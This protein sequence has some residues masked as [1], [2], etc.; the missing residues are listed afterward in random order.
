MSSRVFW[1]Q[2]KWVMAAQ[3]QMDLAEQN[4]IMAKLSKKGIH[5]KDRG[6]VTY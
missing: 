6:N 5:W 1:L 2:T 4:W 3:N